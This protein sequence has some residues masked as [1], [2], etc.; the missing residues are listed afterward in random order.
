[1]SI[2]VEV[3]SM[4]S[5]SE[6]NSYH[7]TIRFRNFS[8][9]FQAL[10]H[11][12]NHISFKHL[13]YTDWSSQQPDKIEV[14]DDFLEAMTDKLND[15]C[16][17]EVLTH[18]STLQLLNISK[19]NSRIANIIQSYTRLHMSMSCLK[20]TMDSVG[21]IGLLNFHY[22][23]VEYGSQIN[24]LHVEIDVFP[25]VFG[26]YPSDMKYNILF[27]IHS[28]QHLKRLS[29]IGFKLE[30]EE[31]QTVYGVKIKCLIDSMKAK[32]V[33]ILFN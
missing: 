10:C 9:A 1:M 3:I 13:W 2:D 18:L 15:D 24:E 23:L 31:N 7:G 12:F 17:L 4:R 25:S 28:T 20:I 22:I 33:D 11:R 5:D 19:R 21:L 14:E 27:I 32:G 29:L 16:I 8:T 6:T 26:L 30:S